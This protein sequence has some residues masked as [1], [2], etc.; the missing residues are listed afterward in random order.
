MGLLNIIRRMAL[1]ERK[2][3]REISRRTGLSRNTITKYLNAGTI[4]PTFT[5]P[6]RPSKLDPFADKLSS[7]LRTEAGKSRK[8]RRTLKQLHADLVVLGFTGSYG[9]VAAFARAWRADRQ[10]EQQ[11]TGRGI[12]VPLSFRPGEAFQFDWSEDYAVIGGERVKL[13]VAHLKLSHSRA[14]LVRA[15]L[16]QTHEML[17]DAHWHGFRVFGGVP[18]RG[19][20]DNMKTAVDRVGRGKERQVNIRFLAM[21]NHYVFAPEFC[22]PAAGWEKGQVEKNVQDSRPRL[23]QQMPEFPDLA[24]LNAWLEQRCQDLWRET[25][26]GNLPGTIADV[27]A[28][29]RAVLMALPTAFDGF[30]EQCKRVSPTC[31]ITFERNRYS[32]PASFANRP[33][34]LRIYPERLVVAAE[35]NILCEHARIIERSHDKPTRTIYNWR[36]YLTVIQRKPGA[37][38]NGAPFLELPLAFRRLQDQMLRRSGGDREMVDILALVLHHDE[39]VVVR[40]VELALDQGVAT[41]THVLNLLHM[42]IDGKTTDGPNIDTPPALALVREPEANVE[43]Y[44]GLRVRIA[45]GRHA[46]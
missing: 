42:L 1:R 34:S 8:Q 13:Q 21:T 14:F 5:V 36:H 9:R 26:H 15:Y 12:F 23:W 45:G 44:D 37:L 10:R 16:L 2:S 22:N 17:F 29:E 41:K 18:G 38:R 39:Q 28:D 43:R 31:L 25:P 46:S 3:I 7:W 19:I 40:A 24:T 27:W 33:V 6:E 4:E 20:Y 11:T 30:V 32:V 35:G